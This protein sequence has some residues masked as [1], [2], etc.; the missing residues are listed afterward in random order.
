MFGDFSKEPTFPD[1]LVA[2]SFGRPTP[3]WQD[4]E[5]LGRNVCLMDHKQDISQRVGGLPDGC[6]S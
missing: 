1:K 4:N 6:H 2:V 5:V 3:S